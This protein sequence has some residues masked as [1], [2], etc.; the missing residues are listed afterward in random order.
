M[1]GVETKMEHSKFNRTEFKGKIIGMILGDGCLYRRKNACLQLGHSLKQKEYFEKKVSVLQELTE[2][3][4]RIYGNAIFARTKCHPLYTSLAERFY[5]QGRKTV[6]NFLMKTLSV[7]GLA[8]WYFDDGT[9]K[10]GVLIQ[11]AVLC[12]HAFNFAEQQLM[13]YWLFKKFGLR[14]EPKRH[15]KYFVLKCNRND[16]EKLIEMVRPFAT[17][18]MKYKLDNHKIR[19]NARLFV[20]EGCGKECFG[21][22][23]LR[24]FCS[25]KCQQ[26]HKNNF[27]LQNGTR[28]IVKI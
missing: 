4:V 6:D 1:A 7:E 12:T 17:S 11:R 24:K 14:F 21:E 10:D 23:R 9:L 28:Q 26:T 8:Y 13:A 22:N 3:K 16:T 27:H 2:V 19:S 18:D 20:C 15:G 25:K 5:H